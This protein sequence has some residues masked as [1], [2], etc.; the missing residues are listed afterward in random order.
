MCLDGLVVGIGALV[1]ERSE[2]RGCYV[3]PQAARRGCGSALV[4]EIE[5][6]A[7]EHGLTHL[8]L[9]AS[10]NAAAFHA[11]LG[12][13]AGERD[14]VTLRNGGKMAAVWVRKRLA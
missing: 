6:I 12:I 13:E 8:E 7:G 9:A 1:L 4:R 11:A 3:A 5:R 2:L 14:E 10:L